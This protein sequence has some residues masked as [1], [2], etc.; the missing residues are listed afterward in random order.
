MGKVVPAKGKHLGSKGSKVVK[1]K[2]ISPFKGGIPKEQRQAKGVPGGKV[3]AQRGERGQGLKF[4]LSTYQTVASFKPGT[5]IKYAP[6]PKT[7]GSKSFVRYAKYE[8]SQTVGEALKNGS[9]VA[10]LCWELSRGIYTVLGGERSETAEKAAIGEHWF[11]KSEQLLSKFNGPR[12]LNMKLHD[13]KAKEALEKEEAW[14]EKKLKK[15]QELAKSLKIKVE[16]EEEL[17][18]MGI[19]EAQDRHAERKVC[20]FVCAKKLT[21]AAKAGKKITDADLKEVMGLWGYAQNIGRLN[22][23]REGVKYVYSD[24][25]G[26]IRGRSKGYGLTPPTRHYPNFVKLLCK[27]LVDNKLEEKLGCEF[28]CTAINLNANYAGARHRDGNNFGPSFLAAFGDF[29]G[30][31]LNAWP[32]DDRQTDKLA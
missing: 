24:T 15:V 8:K 20:D 4:D 29:E 6:N 14:R 19:H 7:P 28:K 21:E 1:K 9:K 12:G 3:I 25:I 2:A 17:K 13:P 23:M 27:W 22:V 18:A 26:A 5:K 32:E 31:Q 10:D 16:N 11:K 30:G